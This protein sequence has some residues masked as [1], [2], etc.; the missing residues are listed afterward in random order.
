MPR[1]GV[2]QDFFLDLGGHSL[3]AAQMVALLRERA[4]VH[5]AVRDVYSHPTVRAMAAYADAQPASAAKADRPDKGIVPPLVLRKTS[6]LFTAAQMLCIVLFGALLSLPLLVVVPVADDLLRQ[7][8]DIIQA[9]VIL[10]PFG[11]ALWLFFLL[12]SIAAKWLIIGRYK[13][14]AYP[15]WGAYHFRLWFAGGF[16]A[17]GGIGA[18]VGTPLMPVYLRLM[19]AKIGR[20]VTISTNLSSAW[21]MVS[22]GDNASVGAETQILGY[23]VEDGYLVIAPVS[24]G[25]DCFV[26]MQCSLGLDSRMGDGSRLDDMP[27]LPDGIEMAEGEARRGIPALPVEAESGPIG[28]EPRDMP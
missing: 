6:P 7:R 17:L 20:D 5:I 23:R 26:G 21:D 2:T 14:G 3:L 9:M 4:G 19:G 16:V 1:V 8:I 15:L 22:I 10:I 27:L 28:R 12:L 18:I 25:H 11:L 13:A 24:I